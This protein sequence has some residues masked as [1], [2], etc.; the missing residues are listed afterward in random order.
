MTNDIQ[1]IESAG[2]VY[3]EVDDG[4]TNGKFVQNIT[5]QRKTYNKIWS[6][7]DLCV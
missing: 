1:N 2:V 7:T 5:N 3:E 6:Q 4:G